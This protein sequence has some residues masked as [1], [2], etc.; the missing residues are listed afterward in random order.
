MQ[1]FRKIHYLSIAAY[2]GALFH[3]IYSGTDTS[4]AW[5]QMLYLGTS[6]FTVFFF[7]QW[8]FTL[9]FKKKEKDAI[10]G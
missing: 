7:S 1:A 3:S 2:V 4:I 10:A 8:M 6:L 9:Y 5:V